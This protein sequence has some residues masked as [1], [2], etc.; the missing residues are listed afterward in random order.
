[1]YANMR[2]CD[3]ERVYYDGSSMIFLNGDMGAQGAQF[4]VDEVTWGSSP[5][6]GTF[7]LKNEMYLKE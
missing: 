5:K 3:G 4:S 6:S 2:G 1:M 7:F